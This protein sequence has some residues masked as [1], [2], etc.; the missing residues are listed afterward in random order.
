MVD[1][2]KRFERLENLIV[3]TQKEVLNIDELCTLTGLSKSTIY[4]NTMSGTE[5]SGYS[6]HPIRSKVYNLILD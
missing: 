6:V 2:I 3:S 4:K 1:L 5:Y